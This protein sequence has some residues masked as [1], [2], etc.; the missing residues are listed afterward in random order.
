MSQATMNSDDII[1]LTVGGQLFNT[2]RSTLCVMEGTMLEAMFS[3]RWDGNHSKDQQGNIF[4]DF[5]PIILFEKLLSLRASTYNSLSSFSL[6]DGI[7]SALKNECFNMLDYLAILPDM[8]ITQLEV[9]RRCDYRQEKDERWH[10]AIVTRIDIPE[11]R[12]LLRRAGSDSRNP[13][14]WVR[15]DADLIAPRNFFIRGWN[16]TN[17]QGA[18]QSRGE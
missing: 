10:D 16:H 7:P 2:L 5:T 12:V 14:Q 8:M 13:G 15:I 6:S 11:A 17:I 9:Q 3:G 1:T 4:L 18:R